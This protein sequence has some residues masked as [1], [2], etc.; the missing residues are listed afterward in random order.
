MSAAAPVA[1]AD[2]GGSKKKKTPSPLRS[3][4]AGSTAGAVEIAITYP[5]EF[6]KTRTQL[7]RRLA[8]GQKL[9]WPKFGPQWYAGCTTLIIGNSAKAGIRFVAFDQ[10]KRLLAD[11]NGKMT[12]PRTVL[13]GFGAGVTESLLAVTPTESIKTT[14]IDDRKRA[15]PRLRGFLHAVPII[16]RERG[17]RGF[18]QGFVPTT[19]RQAANSAVRFSSYTFFKQLAESYTAPGEKL[20]TVGTFSMG[21]LAGLVT[22]A[23]TQPL[24]TIKTRMQSIEARSVYGNSLRC[25][26]LIFKQE[27]LLTFWSG[28]LP[29]L[30]RLVMSGGIV[31]TMYEK[32]I[33]LMDRLDP[34]S[35]YI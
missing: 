24:D 8:D 12:G 11:E 34:E 29:R 32:S 5:A 19:A 6:A 10:Y 18:F 27:G 31:F 1:A 14:L 30:A 13:A 3:I 35:R 28:A 16:A 20:G 4:I 26:A 25:A 2:A 22:V 7:N 15:Q 23:V 17:L 21:A 9:P 33:D